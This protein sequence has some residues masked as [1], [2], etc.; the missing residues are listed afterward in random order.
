MHELAWVL[1]RNFSGGP[2]SAN[3]SSA[4]DDP[5]GTTSLEDIDLK[6]L[7][8]RAAAFLSRTD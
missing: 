6:P 4:L 3:Q 7:I 5:L 1:A 8:D 2:D